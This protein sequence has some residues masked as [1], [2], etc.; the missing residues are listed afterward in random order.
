MSE[1]N[2]ELSDKLS[3][4]MTDLAEKVDKQGTSLLNKIEE[5]HNEV[6]VLQQKVEENHNEVVELQ[7]NTENRFLEIQGEFESKLCEIKRD[8]YTS[9][10]KEKVK[11]KDTQREH[12]LPTPRLQGEENVI[13]SA[14]SPP[15]PSSVYPF[16]STAC[17]TSNITHRMNE[18]RQGTDDQAAKQ[19]HPPALQSIAPSPARI[20]LH[21]SP[22]RTV[23]PNM[24]VPEFDGN[25]SWPVFK[26]QFVTACDFNNWTSKE[27]ATALVLAL[28]GS[29][30]ELLQTI[31]V[32]QQM[33]FNSL[34]NAI[35]LRYGD[36]HL[37]QVYRI[38][39]RNRVQR[40]NESLQE[41]QA[42]VERLAHLAYSHGNLA[43]IYYTSYGRR[44]H[45]LFLVETNYSQIH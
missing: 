41:L 9:L 31:S 43:T 6:V 10:G 27:R 34:V 20:D 14:Y 8:L 3:D 40:V 1:Q 38:Q 35:E 32:D 15:H 30:A 33:D 45:Y 42:D 36:G 44:R 2:K 5:N 12:F 16:P 25:S 11:E 24:R 26:R 37:Q 7:R 23:V 19:L 39:L 29:A 13:H 17:L 4:K 22:F 28:R 21:A 18:E